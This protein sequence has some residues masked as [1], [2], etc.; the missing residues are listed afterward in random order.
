MSNPLHFQKET[1]RV[2]DNELKVVLSSIICAHYRYTTDGFLC[3]VK[4]VVKYYNF[5]LIYK[6][7]SAFNGN[8]V[9]K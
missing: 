5:I 9:G 6:F 1:A 2:L 8:I 7:K 4:S 3:F